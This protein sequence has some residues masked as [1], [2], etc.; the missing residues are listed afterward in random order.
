M[1]VVAGQF[2]GLKIQTPVGEH[3]RPTLSRVKEAFFSSIQH[4]IGGARFLDLFAGTGQM[5][6][7]A[8]SRGAELVVFCDQTTSG[9]VQANVANLDKTGNLA[10]HYRVLAIDA[11]NSV[12]LTKLAP[13]FDYIYLDPPHGA[14]VFETLLGVLVSAGLIH[15]TTT[16]VIEQRTEQPVAYAGFDTLKRK[17][18]GKTMLTYLQPTQPS[19]KD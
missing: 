7:E 4:D 5:G 14:V 16:L 10:K 13:A 2:R 18:Y 6:I 19:L 11:T 3:T 1:Q 12:S 9:L 8:L 17:I 15:D